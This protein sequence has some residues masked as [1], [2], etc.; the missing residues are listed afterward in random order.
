MNQDGE[1]G[2]PDLS[3]RTCIVTGASSGIGKATAAAL[4]SMRA[5]VVLVCRNERRGELARQEIR[6]RTGNDGIELLLADFASLRQVRDV[7]AE[8]QKRHERLHVLVNNAG[9]F[10]SERSITEDGYETTFAVN[11]LAP[12]LL[13]NLLLPTLVGSAPSRI[14]NV[15]STGHGYGTAIHFDD[16]QCEQ[17]YGA[18]RAYSQS[19]LAN[20]LFTYELAR[21]LDGSG[22]TANCL[23]PGGVNTEL[24]RYKGIMGAIVDV[25]RKIGKPFLLSPERGAETSVYLASSP[26]ADGAGGQY[27]VKSRP[28]RSSKASYDEETARRLWTISETLTGITHA[29]ATAS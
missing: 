15:S 10:G 19:K 21:R 4:A 11:H 22:V 20:V 18:M 28:V 16:L 1:S 25:G 24:M 13:T 8:F 6:E 27:F 9:T 3:G 26:K 5:N 29:V 12:F 14:V 2:Q 17:R 7:A 23:H